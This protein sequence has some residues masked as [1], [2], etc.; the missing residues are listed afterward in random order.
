MII[1]GFLNKHGAAKLN[2]MILGVLSAL[3]GTTHG[4]GEILQGNTAPD[5]ILI[6]SWIHEPM[7]TNMGGEPAMTIIPNLLVTGIVCIIVSLIMIGWSLAFTSK[8]KFGLGL[9]LLSLFLLLVG[10]GFGP[11]IIGIFAG[12]AGNGIG[13]QHPW[14]S[15]RLKGGTLNSFAG[16]WPITFIICMIATAFLVVGSLVLVFLF[17]FNGQDFFSNLFFLVIISLILTNVFGVAFDLRTGSD[18]TIT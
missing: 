6:Y 17:S 16:L 10:G 4:I 12:I 7:F 11:P 15:K 2:A 9:L 18:S 13:S 8:S 3:G 5:G 1:S 14:W